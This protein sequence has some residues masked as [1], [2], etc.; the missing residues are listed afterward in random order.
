MATATFKHVLSRSTKIA[1]TENHLGFCKSQLSLEYFIAFVGAMDECELD[2][3]K[4]KHVVANE[5]SRHRVCSLF[6]YI[7]SWHG[8]IPRSQTFM[9]SFR[10]TQFVLSK[11][12]PRC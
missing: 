5:M 4:C 6:F 3:Y 10:N 9:N 7:L 11:E 8:R 1:E 12:M 2:S